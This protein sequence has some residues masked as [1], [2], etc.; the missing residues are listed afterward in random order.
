MSRPATRLNVMKVP[1]AI[2]LTNGFKPGNKLGPGNPNWKKGEPQMFT[3]AAWML[4]NDGLRKA[5]R[6]K[7][8]LRAG[9]KVKTV[10][11]KQKAKNEKWLTVA[12]EARE[13]QN[14]A[15]EYAYMSIEELAVIIKDPATPKAVKVSAIALMHERAYGKPS[16]VNVNANV[17]N[18]GKPNE[19]GK[20]E[21]DARIA[22]TLERV[23]NLTK[24]ARE[25]APS[26]EQPADVRKLH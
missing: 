4:K 2:R 3:E 13:I 18:S 16:Q 25:E 12:K 22:T 20:D 23:E 5:W 15:R 11:Q 24:R 1:L 6:V 21:L 19:L 10:K 7:A 26:Q 17:H 8:L 9:K 14:R